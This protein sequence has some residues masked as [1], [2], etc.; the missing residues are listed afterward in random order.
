MTYTPGITIVTDSLLLDHDTGGGEHPEI[1]ERL[2]AIDRQL[3]A[4]HLAPFLNY[5]GPDP[6]PRETLLTFHTEAWLFRFEE[7]VLSGRTYID[8][9]DNQVCYESYDVATS[10][11]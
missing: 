4:G 1:P 2:Q 9:T 6:A 5:I 11:A 3:Q 8:H 7:S 10:S